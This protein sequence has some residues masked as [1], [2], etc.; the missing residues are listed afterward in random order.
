MF[1]KFGFSTPKL[2]IWH[3]DNLENCTAVLVFKALANLHCK[4]YSF[5]N[6]SAVDDIA[7]PIYHI[8]FSSLHPPTGPKQLSILYFSNTKFYGSYSVY[9][10]YIKFPWEKISYKSEKHLIHSC[11]MRDHLNTDKTSRGTEHDFFDTQQLHI[12]CTRKSRLKHL[13]QSSYVFPWFCIIFKRFHNGNV[14]KMHNK[15]IQ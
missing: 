8:V 12:D 5:R 11:K 1:S 7:W 14:T 6:I 13:K 10:R 9:Q 15:G 2:G 4:E 3:R